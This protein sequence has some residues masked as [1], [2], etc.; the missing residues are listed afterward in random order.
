MK[1]ILTV[2]HADGTQESICPKCGQVMT[3]EDG[4]ESLS[5]D[6]GNFNQ[7]DNGDYWHCEACGF[8]DDP[9]VTRELEL[10]WC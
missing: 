3:L 9:E 4:G 7:H 6:G 1:R 5:I 8:V 10:A 2:K